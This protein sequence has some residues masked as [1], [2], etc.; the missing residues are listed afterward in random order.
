MKKNIR[1]LPAILTDNPQALEKMIRQT[2]GFTD[3][4]QLDIMDGQFVPSHSVSCEQVAA[5]KTTLIWEAHLMVM[6][7]ESCLEDFSRAGAQQIT[8]H[9]E[10]TSTPEDTL[11][12]I[13]SLGLKSG[14]A[15]NPETPISAVTPLIDRLDSVLFLSVNPGFYGSKFIPEVMEKI[16]DFRR[17]YPEIEI[18]IDGGI[19]EGNIVEVART[20][21]D[22]ICVGSAILAQPDPAASYRRLVKLVETTNA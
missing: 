11:T 22:I 10:A 8:F 2:E 20:G 9:Y 4:A 17:S 21:V 7:P 3:H 5:L 13:K 18:A 1:I 19:K 15:I 16:I 6:H 12:Q 14:L